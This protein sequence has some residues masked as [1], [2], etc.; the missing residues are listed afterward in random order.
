MPALLPDADVVVCPS[1]VCGRI[2][3]G[4]GHS[5][6]IVWNN[7]VDFIPDACVVAAGVS[8][9]SDNIHPGFKHWCVKE[10]LLGHRLLVGRG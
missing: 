4:A 8:G 2:Y 5:G 6:H 9:Q 1:L 3:P 7:G 10:E